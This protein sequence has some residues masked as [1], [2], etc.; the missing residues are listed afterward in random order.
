MKKG[1]RANAR[2]SYIYIKGKLELFS[3]AS[4]TKTKI[5]ETTLQETLVTFHLKVFGKKVYSNT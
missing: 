3:C 2:V 1:S 4:K 5:K